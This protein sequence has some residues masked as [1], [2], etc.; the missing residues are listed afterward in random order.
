MDEKISS[1]QTAAFKHGQKKVNKTMS[2]CTMSRVSL[3]MT[4]NIV[5]LCAFYTTL[6]E[7]VWFTG[8]CFTSHFHEVST[9]HYHLKHVC[10]ESTTHMLY[11]T[12]HSNFITF[13]A[14]IPKHLLYAF[15]VVTEG[16]LVIKV[17]QNS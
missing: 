12:V 15:C 9:L 17:L 7:L 10:R 5:Q 11:R 14:L 4:C 2:V 3:H 16:G 8:K 6:G 1:Q 13:T